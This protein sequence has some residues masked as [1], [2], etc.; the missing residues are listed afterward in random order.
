METEISVIKAQIEAFRCRLLELESKIQSS[1]LLEIETKQI[2]DENKHNLEHLNRRLD[3]YCQR[4]RDAND[5][6]NNTTRQTQYLNL[7]HI[8]QK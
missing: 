1:L 5:E 2:L 7:S 6:K 4:C 3:D 8:K